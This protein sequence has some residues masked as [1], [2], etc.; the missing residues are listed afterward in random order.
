M[1]GNSHWARSNKSYTAAPSNKPCCKSEQ[2]NCFLGN[3]TRYLQPYNQGFNRRARKLLWLWRRHKH[4]SRHVTFYVVAIAVPVSPMVAFKANSGSCVCIVHNLLRKVPIFLYWQICLPLMP[5]GQQVTQPA[6][7]HFYG[8][9]PLLFR[10]W[11][12]PLLDNLN[13]ISQHAC[14]RPLWWPL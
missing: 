8:T 13:L 6:P 1:R 11:N 9:E 5:N 2:Q 3:E 14:A 7:M 4:E 12:W 10:S